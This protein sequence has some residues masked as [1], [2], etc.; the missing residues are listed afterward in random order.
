[1]VSS[2][3]ATVDAYLEELPEPRRAVVAAVR[4]LVNRHLPEGYAEGMNWGMISWEIPLSRYPVTYNGQPLPYVAL[5]A[6]K[7]YFALYLSGCGEGSPH[8]AA[9]HQ[10]YAEAGRKLDMGKSCL[11]FKAL[12]E[13]LPEPVAA[14]I[15][16]TPVDVHI[17]HYEASRA[18]K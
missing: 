6:Q 15:A 14:V 13:L 7:Q 11:R 10:A 8:H 12:D 17:A 1:M 16:S 2:K 18:R 4:D 3:A 5:A 9:L